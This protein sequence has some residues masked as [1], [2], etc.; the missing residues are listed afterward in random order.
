MEPFKTFTGKTV[1]LPLNDVD[2][3][4]IIPAQ[5]LTSV[6]RE[7]YG[8]NL[9]RRLRDQDPI[10]PL[11][12]EKFKGASILLSGDNFGCGSSREHAVWALTGAGIKVV[13][14]ESFADIFSSNSGKNGLVLVTLPPETVRKLAVDSSAGNLEVSVSLE[15]LEVTLPDGTKVK[16]DYDPFRRHC[17]LNGLDDMSYLLNHKDEI[18]AHFELNSDV[19]FFSSTVPNNK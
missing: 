1:P 18:K 6:S 11:N 14:A 12:L 2:T 7:G 13:I 19:R 15:D 4:M 17:L 9:F 8:E 16:F 3:D 10:F 5:Y